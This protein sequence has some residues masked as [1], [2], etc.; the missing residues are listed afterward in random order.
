[1]LPLPL[2]FTG[3]RKKKSKMWQEVERRENQAEERE[4][5][6]RR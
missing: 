5:E 1:M 2:G 6:S 4:I 3:N